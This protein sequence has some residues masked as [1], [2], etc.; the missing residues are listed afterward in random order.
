MIQSTHTDDFQLVLA[1][2]AERIGILQPVVAVISGVADRPSANTLLA[3]EIEHVE[4]RLPDVIATARSSIESKGFKK[5]FER[6]GYPDQQG[7]FERLAASFSRVGF[8]Q[9]NA[10]VD[11]GNLASLVT[12]SPIGCHDL[13]SLGGS[14]TIRRA[15]EGDR[16]VPLFQ[17]KSRPIPAGDL[18]YESRQ[19]ITCW[20]GKRDLDSDAH[21]ITPQTNTIAVMA[22]GNEDAGHAFNAHVCDTLF[23]FIQLAFAD[24]RMQKYSVGR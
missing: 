24:A 14:L 18:V 7:A 5:L 10:V 16:I 13:H 17:S 1:P 6:L 9:I 8:K 22:I 11:A 15:V 12:G 3:A 2:C 21:A 19:G 4:S 23:K 20:M